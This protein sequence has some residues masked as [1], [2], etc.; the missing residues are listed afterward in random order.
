MTL[1]G[2]DFLIKL[3]AQ[4]L[5]KIRVFC[6][7]K[8]AMYLPNRAVIDWEKIFVIPELKKELL[9]RIYEELMKENVK[10]PPNRKSVKKWVKDDRKRQVTEKRNPCG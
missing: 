5:L 8:S 3:S 7:M 6:S 2:E 1:D 10:I 9:F 4:T